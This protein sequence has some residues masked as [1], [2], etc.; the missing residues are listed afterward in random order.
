M[1]YTDFETD[2]RLNPLDLVERMAALNEWSFERSAEDE[3]TIS[4]EGR[5]TDCHVSF[6]WMDEVEALC[7][8]ICILRRGK[9]VFTGTV[10]QAKARCGC[11]DFEDAYLMLSEDEREENA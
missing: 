1:T 4:L 5:W 7:D 10:A 11:A 9:T 6:Q 3:I 2:T 8:A